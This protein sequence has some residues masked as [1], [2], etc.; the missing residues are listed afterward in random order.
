MKK[1]A[2]LVF[3]GRVVEMEDDVN[4]Q[5]PIAPPNEAS[6]FTLC[7]VGISRLGVRQQ[8]PSRVN[9][10]IRPGC[11]IQITPRN[12]STTADQRHTLTLSPNTGPERI[13]GF[14]PWA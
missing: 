13:V 1:K 8:S 3:D 12:P 10:G 4:W 14:C 2:R 5:Y 7:C 11:M 6:C 9:V